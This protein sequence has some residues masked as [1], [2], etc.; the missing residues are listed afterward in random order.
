MSQ[1][2]LDV[3]KVTK[4][5]GNGLLKSQDRVVALDSVDLS[6]PHEPATIVAVAGESGSGKTTLAK[7]VLGFTKPTAGQILFAGQDVAD[8]RGAQLIEYRRQ[9]QAIFQD[10]YEVFNPFYRVN[11]VFDQVIKH[12][13][14]ADKGDDPEEAVKTALNMTGLRPEDVLGK[15]PHQLS[16][17]QRQRIM[18]A[19][20]LMLRP[21]LI[22]ADEPVSMIDASLR[23]MILEILQR[24]RN[25]QSISFLYITHD[26]STAYQI[27]DKIYILY[28][29]WIV[30]QGDTA[31]VIE[32]PQH[33]YLQLLIDSV[34]IP[35][36]S[37]RWDSAISLGGAVD[38]REATGC[39]FYSRC[40]ARTRRCLTK[41]PSLRPIEGEDHQVRCYL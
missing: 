31:R 18:I 39:P 5:F 37:Q 34:P 30:E 21:R 28:R 22:L 12:F 11:H 41:R 4:A 20:A 19:R 13:Q 6:I 38:G 3:K 35:D 33:P 26:L 16:G 9:V 27:S 17:G 23:A 32:N 14:L 8:L 15:Y 25:E 2:L 29:G 1:A 10:P 36:P 7:L 40:P 24:M